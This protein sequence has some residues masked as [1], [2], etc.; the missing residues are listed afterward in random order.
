ME[1]LFIFRDIHLF[2]PVIL[3]DGVI[4]CYVIYKVKLEY[5]AMLKKLGN[6]K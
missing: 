2:S 1:G 5:K 3:R 6:L 4:Y